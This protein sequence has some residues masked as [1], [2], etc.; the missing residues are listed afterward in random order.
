MFAWIRSLMNLGDA[1]ARSFTTP[2]PVTPAERGRLIESLD[3]L[4]KT[5]GKACYQT[6]TR[7]ASSTTKDEFINLLHC[8]ALVGSAVRDGELVQ[9]IDSPAKRKRTQLFNP[10]MVNLFVKGGNIQQSI[11]LLRKPM[12]GQNALSIK[13]FRIGRDPNSDVLMSDFAISREHAVVE[14][15][16][17]SYHLQDLASSNGTFV[18][19]TRLGRDSLLLEEGDSIRFARY[20]FLFLGAGDLYELLKSLETP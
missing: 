6:L 12:E 5:P 9:E 13:V 18:N 8:P 11:F 19:G 15:E 3:E 2:G 1:G 17:D 10:S 20:E 4:I 16:D 14:L 7:L